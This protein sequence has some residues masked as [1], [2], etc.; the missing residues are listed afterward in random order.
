[1][2]KPRPLAERFNERVDRTAGPDGCWIWTATADRRGYGMIKANNRS[3]RASRVS[4]ELYIGPI[5]PGM[6]VCHRCDTPRCVNPQ[7]LFLGTPGENSRDM[8][9]KGRA[10][11]GDTHGKRTK[12]EQTARGERH[13]R[14]KL[15]EGDVRAI[16]QRAATG[17]T[18]RSLADAYGIN[19]STIDR[20]L[21]GKYWSHVD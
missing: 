8:Q 2:F 10:A 21:T 5:P 1:M 14:A 15:T 12:P 11:H 9:R 17:D 13:G 3:L 18:R 4:Y 16:R 20:I 19:K 6:F 7:H